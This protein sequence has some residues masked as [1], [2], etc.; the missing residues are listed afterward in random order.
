M[1][2]NCPLICLAIIL[3]FL[4]S[5]L[6]A[7]SIDCNV[8]HLNI[9]ERLSNPHITGILVDKNGHLWVGTESGL[10]RYDGDKFLIY[11]SLA[12]T[13]NR[14]NSII[15]DSFGKLWVGTDEGLCSYNLSDD[16]FTTIWKGRINCI[17]PTDEGLIFASGNS[18][19]THNN[20]RITRHDSD[21]LGDVI[22]IFSIQNNMYAVSRCGLCSFD[23]SQIRK[24]SISGLN[25]I[26]I[27]AA[28][29]K[30]LIYLSI[31]QRGL[32][33]IDTN[34][35][36]QKTYERITDGV[37][38]GVVCSIQ[39]DVDQDRI[40][41]GTDGDGLCILDSL[42]IRHFKTDQVTESL[43]NTVTDIYID[44]FENI[45]VGSSINGVYCIRPRVVSSYGEDNLS[46]KI[47]TSIC[48]DG[49]DVWIG[50]DGDGVVRYGPSDGTFY[51]FSS[52]RSRKISS[53][54]NFDQRNLIVSIYC[55]GVYLLDKQDGRL[56][57]Y[58][59]WDPATLRKELESGS[60]ITLS[61]TPDGRFLICANRTYILNPATGVCETIHQ[62]V[63]TSPTHIC[64]WKNDEAY[65]KGRDGIFRIN[66][67]DLEIYPVID[68]NNSHIHSAA[69]FKEDLYYASSKGLFKMPMDCNCPHKVAPNLVK[70]VTCL[71]AD[72]YGHLWIAA[73]G[74]IFCY[75]G[76]NIIAYD[77]AD[78]LVRSEILCGVSSDE[79]VYFGG[80]MGLSDLKIKRMQNQDSDISMHVEHVSIDGKRI[81]AR[82]GKY[83]FWGKSN[84]LN[85]TYTLAGTDP[86]K[87]KFLKFDVLKDE[88]VC[89]Y[90]GQEL[91]ME[92]LKKGTYCINAF[93]L[94]NDG[95]LHQSKDRLH[96]VLHTPLYAIW[97]LWVIGI[98]G[99]AGALF[100]AQAKNKNASQTILL[101][102][103]IPILENSIEDSDEKILLRFDEFLE[104]NIGNEHLNVDMIVSG[105]AMSRTALYEKIKSLTGL[106]INEYILK[107]KMDKA[108]R[109]LSETNMTISEISDHLGFSSQRYFSTAFKRSTDKSPSEYRKKHKSE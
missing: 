102:P 7:E 67:N 16:T 60:I 80:N 8:R 31:Y 83:H 17:L 86:L 43:P 66:I 46:C 85:V 25:G 98:F 88:K 58:D 39:G 24:I 91:N 21:E 30:D 74:A 29:F 64:F 5:S 41:L 48:H 101:R 84:S 34:G 92:S 70:Q 11:D 105:M 81:K 47:V 99:T 44:P 56:K 93:Y 27:A 71:I 72:D 45:Y 61:P 73:D 19:F 77:E 106:G 53:I 37:N 75:D 87:R 96:L 65:A 68:A 62:E 55:E 95:Q 76:D 15:E 20:G 13:G 69:L 22:S 49:E 1:S 90:G 97:W 23:G 33:A 10:N 107:V 4:S 40:L 3:C 94:G 32:L 42:G 12:I 59:I 104:Q 35:N 63:G 38:I 51:K 36:I 18:L 103:N 100:Y 78:G 6:E 52:T 2:K 108:C 26:I 89:E 82:D 57:K 109:Y 14:I 50:T 9:A 79:H 28:S 54:C